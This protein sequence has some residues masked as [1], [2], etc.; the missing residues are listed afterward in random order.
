MTNQS[1][2]KHSA[3]VCAAVCFSL[4]GI[5]DAGEL[6]E[7]GAASGQAAKRWE[8]AFVTGNG[9]MGA[10]L[11]GDPTNETFV[12]NHCRLFLP[13]GS[14]EIPS[15][16]WRPTCPSSAA[17]SARRATRR[18]WISSTSRAAAQGFP[19]LTPTDP[20]HPGFF[21]H[22]RQKPAGR[23]PGLPAHRG[24][25]H[26][27]GGGAVERRPRRVPPAAV[28]VAAGQP[29]RVL[30]HRPGEG[31]A[32]LRAGVPGPHA[33]EPEDHGRRMAARCRART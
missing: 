23:D 10:M 15:P 11:F 22:V 19:G 1:I 20:L 24:L 14:R 27:R 2:S 9:R 18:P 6:P 7:R 30:A 16:T 21:V 13:L 29:D 33:A 31:R 3:A 32:R 26:R 4:T 28:R 17:S 12:A 8:E 5:P 25:P